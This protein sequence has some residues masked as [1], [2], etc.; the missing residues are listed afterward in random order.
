MGAK[1]SKRYSS[2]KLQPKVLNLFLNFPPN[3]PHKNTLGIS[4]IL[5]FRFLTFFFSFS[6]ISSSLL[7]DMGKSKTSITWKR[8]IVEQNGVKFG[9][10]GSY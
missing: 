1:I 4:E 7:W 8:A 5:S 6:K 3:A 10:H 9:T 2:Y